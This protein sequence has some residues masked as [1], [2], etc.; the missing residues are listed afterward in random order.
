[1]TV[2]GRVSHIGPRAIGHGD[3][4]GQ[5]AA[6]FISQINWEPYTLVD[7]FAEYDFNENLT[8]TFRIEN[9]TDQFYVD[10]LSLV[11]QPG[12]GRTFYA[13]LTAKF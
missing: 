7:V 12:P 8:A 2:G 5:G 4:T 3:V 9:L 13:S 11:Q 6:Q 10:P 1:M